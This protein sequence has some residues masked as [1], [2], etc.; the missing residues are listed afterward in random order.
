[1]FT[2]LPNILTLSRISVIPLLV[3]AFYL[4]GVIGN[5]I[6]FVLFLGAGVTDFLDGYIAR[7]QRQIS[8]LGSFLDPIADKLLVAAAILMLVAFDRIAGWTVLAAVI[9]L[10]REILVS[11]LREFLAGVRVSIP[12]SKLAKW[13][14]TVQVVALAFLLIG[15]AA[16]SAIPAAAIGTYALWIAALITLY[17]GYG[18]LR[19]GLRHM[20]GEGAGAA[21][22]PPESSAGAATPTA[23]TGAEQAA[24]GSDRTRA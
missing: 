21:A 11:G 20:T 15:D 24:P 23:S 7:R 13:K 8:R 14:T 17:T 1:M 12:V 19:T 4:D 18:Y 9:I 2:G 5:W 16:P 22:G 6:A 3:G 10:C